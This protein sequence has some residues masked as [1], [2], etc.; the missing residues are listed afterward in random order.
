MLPSTTLSSTRPP[1]ATPVSMTP[2]STR[3]SLTRP[4]SMR[5]PSTISLSVKPSS[6]TLL[7]TSQ[8]PLIP[9]PG[10]SPTDQL[11][12]PKHTSLSKVTPFP[13]HHLLDDESEEEGL[14]GVAHSPSELHVKYQD[15]DQDDDQYYHSSVYT[16]EN[17]KHSYQ[18]SP[19]HNIQGHTIQMPQDLIFN[20]Q[21]VLHD[22]YKRFPELAQSVP[23]SQPQ[24]PARSPHH[25][26]PS[27]A[28]SLSFSGVPLS[29]LPL[30]DP[31]SDDQHISQDEQ[32]EEGE[33][34]DQASTS[35][36]WDNYFIQPPSPSQPPLV[37]SPP[38][39]IGGFHSIMERA[40]TRFQSHLTSK[41][42]DCF[43]YDF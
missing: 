3:P 38:D 14:F 7:P 23:P 31:P 13:P 28:T 21:A 8:Q 12:L 29:T 6:M 10:L 4:A 5:P 35:S 19:S 17:M 11:L 41:Q 27:H 42:T 20:L 37:D 26:P 40:A 39:D 1:L 22:Y 36:E 43:L 24:T 25:I 15:D 30:A 2:S 33:L 32:K 16:S 34:R 18:P 9:V